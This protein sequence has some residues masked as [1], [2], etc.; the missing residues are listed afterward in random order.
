MVLSLNQKDLGQ[1]F[2]GLKNSKPQGFSD[3]FRGLARLLVDGVRFWCFFRS[4]EALVGR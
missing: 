3:I 4:I 2:G 1:K